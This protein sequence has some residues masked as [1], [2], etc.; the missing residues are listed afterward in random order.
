MNTNNKLPTKAVLP[1]ALLFI[2]YAVLV[3][4][5]TASLRDLNVLLTLILGVT[6]LIL[7]GPHVVLTVILGA[8]TVLTLYDLIFDLNQAV[9]FR[10]TAHPL[11]VLGLVSVI[12]ASAAYIFV[13]VTSILSLRGKGAPLE[14]Y[15]FIPGILHSVSAVCGFIS[16]FSIYYFAGVINLVTKQDMLESEVLYVVFADFGFN[17]ILT[18]ALALLCRLLT[19]RRGE[20]EL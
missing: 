8:Q 20:T 13:F 14:R 6:L 12:F 1:A 3:I 10:L 4:F 18:A 11:T 7:R 5:L 17:I 15:W 9:I 19:M 2:S 16:S